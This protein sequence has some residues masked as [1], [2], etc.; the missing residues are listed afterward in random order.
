MLPDRWNPRLWVRDWL[1]APSLGETE[2]KKRFAQA[3]NSWHR[4]QDEKDAEAKA[5]AEAAS[6]P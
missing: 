4:K 5:R 6:A 3:L 2:S 1:L